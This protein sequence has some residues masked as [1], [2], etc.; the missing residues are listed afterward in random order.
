MQHHKAQMSHLVGEEV[1]T[2]PERDGAVEL[3]RRSE[4]LSFRALPQ[5]EQTESEV[6]T[7]IQA[8]RRRDRL[9]VQR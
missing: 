5:Q 6:N 2:Q 9:C 7:G 8:E 3:G 4:Q 1:R